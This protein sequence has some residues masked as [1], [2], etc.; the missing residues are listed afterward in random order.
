M[1]I[2]LLVAKSYFILVEKLLEAFLSQT[3]FS[4]N[5]LFSST[6]PK[7]KKKKHFNNKIL[8][9]TQFFTI[10]GSLFLS[11]HYNMILILCLHLIDLSIFYSRP[12]PPPFQV[13]PPGYPFLSSKKISMVA[14]L[15]FHNYREI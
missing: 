15:P 8:I 4:L 14:P 11:I 12:P 7:T 1:R 9:S 10:Y 6:L 3:L 13:F 2:I 5:M